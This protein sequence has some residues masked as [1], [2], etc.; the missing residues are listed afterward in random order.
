MI[1]ENRAAVL[2]KAIDSI[3]GSYIGQLHSATHEH[4]GAI[5]FYGFE[6]ESESLLALSKWLEDNLD[7]NEEIAHA[8]RD[9]ALRMLRAAQGKTRPTVEQ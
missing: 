1:E 3:Q 6:Q 9:E 8:K 5:G 2:Q 7:S 4:G